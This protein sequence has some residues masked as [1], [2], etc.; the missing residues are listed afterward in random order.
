MR[1][2]PLIVFQGLRIEIDGR[3]VLVIYLP[4][5]HIPE[6]EVKRRQSILARINQRQPVVLV[7]AKTDR[8]SDS[9]LVVATPPEWKDAIESRALTFSMLQK[10]PIYD[11]DLRTQPSA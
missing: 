3:E 1:E 9:T 10:I 5:S 4:F 6:D 8:K 11:E 2:E 7:Y